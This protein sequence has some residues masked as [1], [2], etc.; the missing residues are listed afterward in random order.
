[1]LICSAAGL[2]PMPPPNK[3]LLQAERRAVRQRD[4]VIRNDHAEQSS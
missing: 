2:G 1:M 4:L 3:L